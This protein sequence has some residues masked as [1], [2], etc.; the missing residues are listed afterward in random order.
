MLEGF[1]TLPELL[2]ARASNYS[3]PGFWELFERETHATRTGSGGQLTEA[4][5]VR[6]VVRGGAGEAWGGGGMV[7]VV[8]LV[9][10]AL[11]E[12]SLF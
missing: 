7:V 11:K 1:K 8:V 9:A 2:A 6:S 3:P 5:Q 4:V 10:V 12:R